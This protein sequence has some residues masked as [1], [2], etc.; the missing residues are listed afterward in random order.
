MNIWGTFAGMILIAKTIDGQSDCHLE[1]MDMSVIRNGY[2]IQLDSFVKNYR[3]PE[4]SDEEIP[5]V[6]IRLC[7]VNLIRLQNYI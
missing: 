5:L 4:I 2:G 7:F 1:F 6:Y 3:I